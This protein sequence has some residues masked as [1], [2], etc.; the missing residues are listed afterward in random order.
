MSHG[1]SCVKTS[2]RTAASYNLIDVT[3]RFA[4]WETVMKLIA[5]RI[6]GEC[7]CWEV[8]HVCDSGIPV[9]VELALTHSSCRRNRLYDTIN[10]STGLRSL[11]H[12]PPIVSKAFTILTTGVAQFPELRSTQAFNI[13]LLVPAL[14]LLY[15][16]FAT[17]LY[18]FS[19]CFAGSS[20]EYA[21]LCPT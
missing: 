13:A 8:E 5:S 12:I 20:S 6:N 17:G 3:Q 18:G 21:E 10:R 4:P 19:N 7:H 16:W 11:A 1:R 9:I 14:D 15:R 2:K